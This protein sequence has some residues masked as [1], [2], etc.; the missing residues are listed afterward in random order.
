MVVKKMLTCNKNEYWVPVKGH[1]MYLVSNQGRIYSCK[2]GR[3][4]KP[5]NSPKG[6]HHIDL[7]NKSYSFHRVVLMNLKPCKNMK[8]LQ[9]NHIDCNKKNNNLCN[10][11]WCTNGEN[12]RHAFANGRQ[13]PRGSKQGHSKLTEE[14]VIEIKEYL[15]DGRFSQREISEQYGVCKST[16]GKIN[17][18]DNWSWLKIDSQNI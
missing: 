4:L 1:P 6:Y 7:D 16:I 11:E 10:L 17:S 9:V 13:S 12:Q 8:N 14:Q 3:Y 18:G 5:Y 15:A 2:R